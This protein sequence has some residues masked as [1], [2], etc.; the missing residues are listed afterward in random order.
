MHE[1]EW[2]D[3]LSSYLDDDL[4]P[5]ARAEVEAALAASPALRDL[6]DELRA[7][8][9]QAR[10]LADR[11]PAADLW[12]G[13]ARA[14]GVASPRRPA[15][16]H[17]AWLAAAGLA[18]VAG[19][20]AVTWV[21]ATRAATPPAAVAAAAP[22]PATVAALPVTRRPEATRSVA[23][24]EAAL[25]AGRARLDSGTVAVLE[26]NL[27]IIDSALADAERALA[28]DPS[29]AYLNSHL[30]ATYRRKLALLRDAA[31]LIARS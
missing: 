28:A 10:R 8:Q 15:R 2:A 24:L 19:S 25:A 18:L 30:A 7:V 22:A 16:L 3:R 11:E 9:Q 14:I 4:D 27:A 23:A 6:L 26:R 1:H 21:V 5:A 17:G 12:P 13:I 20:A 29:N 31:A